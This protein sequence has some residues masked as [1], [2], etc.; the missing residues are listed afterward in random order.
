M[1]VTQDEQGRV[2]IEVDIETG[3]KLADQIREHAN[4]TTNGCLALASLLHEAYYNAKNDFRQ[5]P[6]AF[7]EKAPKAPSAS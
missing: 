7:D 5:P 3:F 2:R 4:D 6:H 1:K